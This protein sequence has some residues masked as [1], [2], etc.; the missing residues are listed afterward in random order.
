V[1]CTEFKIDVTWEDAGHVTTPEL[2]ATW[3]RLVIRAGD[4]V[5]TRVHDKRAQTVRD[6]IY[7]SLFPIADWVTRNWFFLQS[8]RANPRRPREGFRTRHGLR[9]GRDGG[10]VPDLSF[11]PEGDVVALHWEPCHGQYENVEFLGEGGVEVAMEQL[12]AELSRVVQLVLDRLDT[13]GVGRTTSLAEEWE[14]IHGLDRDELEFCGACAQLGQDPFAVPDT[15]AQE[16]VNVSD[17]VPGDMLPDFY[18]SASTSQLAS[19]VRLLRDELRTMER[20]RGQAPSLLK[21]CGKLPLTP[22]GKHPWQEGYDLARWLRS[23]LGLNGHLLSSWDTF[24]EALGVGR[25]DRRACTAFG[26]DGNYLFDSL[27]GLNQANSPVF[28]VRKPR[29]EAQ[30]FALC[31][32]LFEYLTTGAPAMANPSHSTRQKRNRAF[33]AEFLAPADQIRPRLANDVVDDETLCE[34]AAE[35]GISDYVIRHQIENH[36]LAALPPSGW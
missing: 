32:V 9:S 34:L 7:L 11:V 31:R 36:Q 20:R 25:A 8:E 30:R 23:H 2:A 16:I 17:L 33:A 5:V 1:L 27:V 13:L 26:G 12:T 35:F 15:V 28:V 4:D 24:W 19:D 14:A 18:D 10:A 6:E 22:A 21:L 29:E 3:A